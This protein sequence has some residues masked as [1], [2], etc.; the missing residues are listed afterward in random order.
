[1]SQKKKKHAPMDRPTFM[2]MWLL[3]GFVI[4]LLTAIILVFIHGTLSQ[5]IPVLWRLMFFTQRLDFL[6]YLILCGFIIGWWQNLIVSYWL[7]SPIPR[8]RLWT[9]LGAIISAIIGVSIFP[10][11]ISAHNTLSSVSLFLVGIS[12]MQYIVARNEM[13]KVWKWVR[14]NI[15]GVMVLIAIINVLGS[16][17][18]PQCLGDYYSATDMFDPNVTSN[19]PILCSS[20]GLYVLFGLIT[21]IIIAPTIFFGITGRTFYDLFAYRNV[22]N[23]ARGEG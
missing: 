8:W 16:I 3:S 12:L 15:M 1:M 9:W 11:R 6:W 18:P 2:V 22:D 19:S 5:L 4:P 21:L 20:G 17:Q 7:N 14:A 13:P 10:S 23:L